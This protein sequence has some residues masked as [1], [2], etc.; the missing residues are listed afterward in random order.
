[1]SSEEAHSDSVR[2]LRLR[3]VADAEPGAL[4]RVIE[5]FQNLNVIPRRVIAEMGTSD[6]LYIQV[7]IVGLT[8]DRMTLIASKI[9]Q[10]TSVIDSFW[11][12][13]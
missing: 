11:H 13:G 4:A 7:D 1:M 9:Q 6:L 12:Y 2:L 5:R 8:E 10:V 3:V